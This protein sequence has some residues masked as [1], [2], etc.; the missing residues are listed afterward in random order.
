MISRDIAKRLRDRPDSEH[1]QAMIRIVIVALLAA[2]YLWLSANGNG[3]AGPY[4]NGFIFAAGYIGLSIV[5]L[6]L[7]V[8]WPGRSAVRRLVAMSTD[9]TTLA[10]LMHWGGEYGA[11]LYPIF[12]WVTLGNGFRYGNRYLA[13][14]AA[15]S[16]VGFLA[17]ILSSAYWRDQPHLAAGLLA[18]LILLPAY[19]STLINKLTVAKAQA[20][21]ANLAKSRFL[22]TMSHEL[23][24]PLNAIIGMGGLLQG[25]R[26]DSDQRD[27]TRTIGASARALLSLIDRILDL[28]R[29]EAGRMTVEITDF[30]LHAEL[31]DIVAVVRPQARAKGLKLVVALDAR[32][33]RRVTGG[34]QYL[35]QILTNLVANGTKFTD[36]GQI[37]V[38]VS[39]AGAAPAELRLRFEVADTGIGIAPAAQSRIFDRFTQEDDATNRRFGGAGLGLAICKQLTQLL[40]GRIGVN[41]EVGRGSRFWVELPFKSLPAGSEQL[42]GGQPSR[43]C[44]V[45]RDQELAGALQR[46]LTPRGIELAAVAS[47]VEPATEG[48]PA[49]CPV[50]IDRRPG[51][52]T[53]VSADLAAPDQPRRP[54]VFIVD[55]DSPQAVPLMLDDAPTLDGARIMLHWPASEE[56]IESALHFVQVF[57]G[58]KDADDARRTTLDD[59][60]LSTRERLRILV[61]ED[62]LINRRVTAKILERAGH[63]AVLVENGD[64]ALDAL[65]SEHFDLALMDINMP[66]ISGLDVVKLY[67]FAHLGD[68]G[69]LPIVALT[70]D[71][72]T[73]TRKACEEAGMDAY[74]TKPVEAHQLLEIIHG[75]VPQRRGDA[76]RLQPETARVTQISSHPRYQHERDMVVDE[77]AIRSLKA[78]EPGST[79]AVEILRDFLVDADELVD[80]MIKAADAGRTDQLRDLAH[81]LRSSAAHVGAVR[82]RRLCSEICSSPR[83]ELEAQAAS[84]TRQLHEQLALYR[85]AVSGQLAMRADED[86]R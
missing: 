72:T 26:L 86:R 63:K 28:S 76:P 6:G 71:A 66:E 42:Q 27:M 53:G 3:A 48:I 29:I 34:R 84:S 81:A 56:E 80:G 18:G 8:I 70:A 39:L 16:V 68:T 64:Q 23:R 46:F 67:R 62:N 45:S 47:C 82:V 83:Q 49:G 69:H 58:A 11:A 35:R 25:T 31:A 61:A 57:A 21:S 19:V 44:L 33:P 55:R 37:E 78:I 60:G 51:Q 54:L 52:E 38:N 12:L 17:A 5:Y 15:V 85:N 10:V 75:L 73:E 43:A 77:A 20:E 65:D 7:I 50:F 14:S 30:D 13:T 1:E 36:Q 22:A 24:T 4:L 59:S 40:G 41:S 32:V 2:Y 74:V 9:H 79:F